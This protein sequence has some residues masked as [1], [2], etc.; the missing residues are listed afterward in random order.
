MS[1]DPIRE[2]DRQDIVEVE[3]EIYGDKLRA[4]LFNDQNTVKP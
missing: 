1:T 4:C 3:E 2:N